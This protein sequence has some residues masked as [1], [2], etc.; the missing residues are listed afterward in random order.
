M[1]LCSIAALMTGAVIAYLIALNRFI[2]S[3][4]I[5]L[6]N[7]EIV[8]KEILFLKEKLQTKIG[9]KDFTLSELELSRKG[10]H[11]DHAANRE[12][13]QCAYTPVQ[14]ARHVWRG[15]SRTNFGECRDARRGAFLPSIY[16]S[17]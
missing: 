3:D 2:K 10:A 16:H 11:D 9:A 8:S 17:E 15:N 6:K 12:A 14:A 4:G 13:H 1:F 7:Q 5:L